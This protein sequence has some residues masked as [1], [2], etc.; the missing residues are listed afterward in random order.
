MP[1][2]ANAVGSSILCIITVA[3]ISANTFAELY[4]IAYIATEK[5]QFFEEL[6]ENWRYLKLGMTHDILINHLIK[7]LKSG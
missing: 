2:T 7:H 6:L 3:V 5:K 4:N 1:F